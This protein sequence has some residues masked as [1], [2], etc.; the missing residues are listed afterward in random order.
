MKYQNKLAG[1]LALGMAGV[2][3]VPTG[4]NAAKT[5]KP[6]KPKATKPGKATTPPATAAAPTTAVPA[7]QPAAAGGRGGKII[8][9]IGAE[10]NGWLPATQNWAPEGTQVRYSILENVM[11]VNDKGAVVGYLAES[12][13]PSADFKTWTFK[14]RPNIKFHNGEA[15]NAA[16]MVANITS[17]QKG[18]LTGPALFN[19]QGCAAAGDLVVACAMRSRWVSFPYFLTGSLGAMAAPAY[20]AA[21]DGT[22][23]PIGTGPFIFKEW[24]PGQ[25]FVATKNPTY[26][27][28]PVVADEV[29]FRVIIDDE[30]RRSQLESGQINFSHTSAAVAVNDYLAAGKAGKFKTIEAAGPAQTNY[31]LLNTAIPPFNVKECRLA[32]YQAMDLDTLIKLRAPGFTKANGPFSPGSLGSLPNNGSPKF[33]LDA[34]KA[35]YAKCKEANGGKD[36]EITMATTTAT[37]AI[38]TRNVKKQMVE[39]AGFV[40][41]TVEIPQQN[42]IPAAI[43][44]RFQWL[45]WRNHGG[46]DPDGE[47]IWWHSE[48]AAP[49]NSQA[50]NFGRVKD[51][52]ID[53]ALDQIRSNSD[54]AVRKKSAEAINQAFGEEAYFIP[55][56]YS[57]WIMGHSAKCG[58]V[59]D[60]KLPNGD[61]PYV[62]NGGSTPALAYMGCAA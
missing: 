48:T 62:F 16:A 56:W 30:A 11:A 43:V 25:K 2:M 17:V 8:Y 35:N 7:A 58:G 33:D 49:V 13:S 57:R 26:W 15:W 32:A 21:A 39:R 20:V 55:N 51:G 40:I 44:G 23:G 45:T 46:S 29:E 1:A 60:F 52:T 24:I 50:L 27:R 19:L 3:L 9:G 59:E 41:K 22:K 6:T 28:G 18:G 34:A 47:R 37:E 12:A 31:D 42:Y 54:P 14:L 53:A 61:K 36:V 10:S 5:P 4:A 38:E